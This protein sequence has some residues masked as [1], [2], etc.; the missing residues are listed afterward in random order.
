[1]KIDKNL[2]RKA[3][4]SSLRNERNSFYLSRPFLYQRDQ[5]HDCSYD[6]NVFLF[7]KEFHA[8]QGNKVR[9]FRTCNPQEVFV[10]F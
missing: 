2:K 6:Y 5:N 9:I 7:S 3:F 8:F 10:N 4:L 1:M